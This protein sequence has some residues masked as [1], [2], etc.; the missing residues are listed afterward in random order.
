MTLDTI[1][2]SVAITHTSGIRRRALN[3]SLPA[4]A[5]LAQPLGTTY[6]EQ[7]CITYFAQWSSIISIFTILTYET[8]IVYSQNQLSTVNS[9][10]FLAKLFTARQELPT[11][12][13]PFLYLKLK[14][15]LKNQPPVLVAS[16]HHHLESN[17]TSI[18]CFSLRLLFFAWIQCITPLDTPSML[19]HITGILVLVSNSVTSLVWSIVN[20]AILSWIKVA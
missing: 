13:L 16:T 5:C 18:S 3:F 19:L 12:T 11:K 2:Q 20:S 9:V 4:N 17:L 15:K 7:A 14:K 6:I 8:L 10:I 1:T